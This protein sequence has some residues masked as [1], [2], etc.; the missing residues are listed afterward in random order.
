MLI[1]D[2]KKNLYYF[3]SWYKQC[4]DTA[5]NCLETEISQTSKIREDRVHGGLLV[6]GELL[7]CA[8]ADWEQINRDLEDTIMP[9]GTNL[10]RP[11]ARYTT[12]FDI[13]LGI[14]FRSVIC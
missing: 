3:Q 10:R 8:N 2:I 5:S 1:D 12:I 14:A 4:Y 11:S 6:M 9:L 13:I 7:R